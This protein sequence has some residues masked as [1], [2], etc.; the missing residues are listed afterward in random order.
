MEYRRFG[1]H[2]LVRIDRGEEVMESLTQMC[3]EEGILLEAVSGLGAADYAK[4]G[5]YRV[6][7]HQFEGREF[8]GEQ[9]VSSIVGS[10][11][12]KDGEPY[13][14]LHI[15]LCDDNMNIHGGHLVRCRISGTCEL[16]VT[17]LEGHVGRAYDEVTGL[18]LFEFD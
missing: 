14:H 7:D 8:E 18:N 12:Q 10:I 15:N 4:V 5:I 2:Y 13:L 9:E 17:V 1:S 11:T 3:R 16:I 6:A